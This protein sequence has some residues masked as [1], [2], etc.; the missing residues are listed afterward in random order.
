[1]SVS[2]TTRPRLRNVEVQR[3]EREGERY[4]LVADPRR[5]A[6]QDVLVNESY[7]Q[8]LALADGAMAIDEITA[9]ANARTGLSIEIGAVVELFQRLDDLFLLDGSRYR[10]EIEHQLNDYRAAEFR[11][12]ALEDQAYPGDPDELLDMFEGFSP[13]TPFEQESSGRDLKALVSPHIDYGRGG[14]TYAELWRRAA[15]DLGDVELVVL[16][17]T[18]HNGAGPRLTLTEQSYATPWNILPTDIELA[19]NCPVSCSG[20]PLWKITRSLMSST[21]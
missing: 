7:G 17:G 20:I 4:F 3:V 13:E 19:G 16:F 12:P 5:V 9:T 2:T 6:N 11:R 10:T 14:D 21:I 8:F 15:P 18:D 1:M